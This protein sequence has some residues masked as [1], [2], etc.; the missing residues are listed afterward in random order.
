HVDGGR[1]RSAAG[2]EYIGRPILKLCLPRRDLVRVDVKMLSQLRQRHVA[3]DGRK[4]HL[5]L[6]GRCVVPTRSSAHGLSCSRPSSPLSGRNSTY[7][8]V[9]IC[10][11]SSIFRPT[12]P[13]TSSSFL[14]WRVKLR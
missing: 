4:G 12:K 11:A 13:S 9:Q 3:L 6:E 2:T 10:E 7:R 8:L 5:R 1:H 14:I